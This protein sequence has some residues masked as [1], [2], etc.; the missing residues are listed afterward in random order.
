MYRKNEL[1]CRIIYS[2]EIT[3]RKEG[4]IK[5]FLDEGQLKEFIEDL[6]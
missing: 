4:A 5:T 2:V 3:F 6:L 1:L